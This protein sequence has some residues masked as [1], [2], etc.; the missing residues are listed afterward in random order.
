MSFLFYSRDCLGPTF[1]VWSS[2]VCSVLNQDI[3]GCCCHQMSYFKAEMHQI[4]LRPG[5]RPGPRWGS[6]QC[7][8]DPLVGWGGGYPSPFPT[9]STPLASQSRRLWRRNQSIPGSAFS[10][11]Q[12]TII[13]AQCLS[14]F[15]V[16]VSPGVCFL[17]VVCCR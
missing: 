16:N 17:R 14:V 1:V 6:L 5:L 15:S 11:I 13:T 4:R 12:S 7:S 2:S 3:I 9:P 8:P 10:V